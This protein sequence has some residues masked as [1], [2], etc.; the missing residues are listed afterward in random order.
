MVEPI[1]KIFKLKYSSYK[2]ILES[3]FSIRNDN[4]ETR[5]LNQ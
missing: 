1:K 3:S 4:W 5:S 2:T